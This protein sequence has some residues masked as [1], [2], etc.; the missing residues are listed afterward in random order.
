MVVPLRRGLAAHVGALVAVTAFVGCEPRSQSTGGP[1]PMSSAPAPGALQSALAPGAVAAAHPADRRYLMHAPK[2]WDQVGPVPLVVSLHGYGAPSGAANAHMLGLDAFADERGFVLVYPDGRPDSQGRRFWTATDACCDFDHAGDDDVAYVSWLIDDVAAKVSVDRARVYVVGYSNGGFL[3]H[4][5]AC[6]IAPRIAGI[7]SI[8][9]AAWKDP[10]RCTPS[11]PVN[12]LEI[13]GEADEV[14]RFGGGRLFDLP[15]AEY[16]GVRDTVAMWASKD[17][18]S[19][20]LRA[21]GDPLDFDDAVGGAETTRSTFAPC[22]DG[23]TV[24]LW[25]T[26][27]GSHVPRPSRAGLIAIW[28]WMQAHP[29]SRPR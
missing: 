15:G 1:P 16:P 20:P 4:R 7:V 25:S 6:E 19:G 24:D 8:G 13:H 27:N 11:E 14:V 17:G 22:R 2:G 12:V 5:L 3:A 9:G 28:S 21:G 29:K 10:S 26:V 23:V 18:C